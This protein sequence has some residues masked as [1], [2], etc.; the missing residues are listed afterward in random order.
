VTSAATETVP[1]AGRPV[2][3]IG[4]GAMQLPGSGV[5]G[6]P[7]DRDAA[8]G[9]LRRAVEL[10]VNHVDTAQYYGPDVANELIHAALHPYPPDLVIVSKVGAKRDA[11]GGWHPAL[12]P[13][14]L[15]AGVED[16][17]RSLEV[18]RIDVVNLRLFDEAGSDAFGEQLEEM[19]AMREEGLIGGIGL[20]NVSLDA[21]EHAAARTEI[22][23]AQNA[24]NL[25]DRAAVPLL[26][27]CR[28][29][30]IPFVPFFPLGS[31]FDPSKPVLAHPAV[32]ATAERLGAMPSQVAMAWLLALAPNTLLIPG[33]SSLEHLEENM[34]AAD[35][36]LDD[37][38]LAGLTEAS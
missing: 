32:R 16:N 15:R 8:L 34:A 4:F 26:E 6:P 7:P 23:C 38:A 3:R 27:R 19:I 21:F 11:D 1:L 9:V 35:L 28:S 14:E 12:S 13:P 31:A 10:G 18:D 33:T 17:L 30:G 22:A 25:V 24:L 5:F 37:E 2:R 29:D 20:S 36:V